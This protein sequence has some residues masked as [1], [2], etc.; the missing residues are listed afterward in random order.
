[1][2]GQTISKSA[3]TAQTLPAA[4]SEATLQGVSCTSRKFCEAVGEIYDNGNVDPVGVRW[5]GSAWSSQTA[6]NPA[7]ST[8]AHEN[9]VSCASASACE[10]GGYF[11]VQVTSNDPKAFAEGWNSGAWKL[12]QAVA[13]AGA[14]ESGAAARG[15]LP[16]IATGAT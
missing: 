14:T 3:W 6:P 13:P 5:N 10:A 12:Q 7:K 2:P 16:T 8:F 15:S 11:Q 9:A 4:A 1:M